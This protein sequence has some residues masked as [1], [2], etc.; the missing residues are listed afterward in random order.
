MEEQFENIKSHLENYCNLNESERKMVQSNLL[1]FARKNR[2][3]F[4]LK[5]QEIKP[6]K[7]SILFE[8][9]ETLSQ[10]AE[11]W[12]DFIISEFNQIILLTETA[13]KKEQ[14]SISDSLTA[15]TF[16]ARQD[17]NGIDKLKTTIKSGLHSKSKNIVKIC[18]DLLSDIYSSNKLKH[19][20][21]KLTIERFQNSKTIEIGQ[22]AK[23][24]ITEIDIPSKKEDSNLKKMVSFLTPSY[25]AVV[26][27]GGLFLNLKTID[28]F[29]YSFV[30]FVS[31]VAI[32]II[33]VVLSGAIHYSKMQK[34]TLSIALGYGF[35][36]AFLFLFLNFN[37]P[38]SES[39]NEIFEIS[40]KGEYGGRRGVYIEF[41]RE[42][43]TKKIDYYRSEKEKIENSNFMKIE[44]AV[45]L[46]G[47]EIMTEREFVNEE[48]EVSR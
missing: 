43:K 5:V 16:F 46:F 29:Q 21:C 15:L 4:L 8:I 7:N 40:K 47:F 13:R 24:L 25:T 23:R 30:P 1:I 37:F 10:E 44:T 27:F 32:F 26:F 41:V 6:G 35:I 17:F 34:K 11:I 2:D 3:F 22:F 9:Y 38:Q 18:L 31:V 42:G 19:S 33:G 36:S 14:E 28:L 12:I 45:G 20:D 39:R 48:K